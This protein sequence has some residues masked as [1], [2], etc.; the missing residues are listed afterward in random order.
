MN[1]SQKI[2]TISA[3]VAA[4]GAIWVLLMGVRQYVYREAHCDNPWCYD[5]SM[6][7]MLARW[8][9]LDI[10]RMAV[11]MVEE[12]YNMESVAQCVETVVEYI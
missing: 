7:L 8:R 9:P 1:F 11:M 10:W 5:S 3:V 12:V 6:C 2:K 4:V